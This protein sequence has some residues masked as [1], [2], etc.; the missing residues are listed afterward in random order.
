[1]SVFGCLADYGRTVDATDIDASIFRK[2]MCFTYKEDI[3]IR[4]IEE[5]SNLLYAAKKYKIMQ[6]DKL[7]EK[8]LMSIIDDD[9]IEEINVLADTYKLKTLRRLTKLHHSRPNPSL[10]ASWMRFEPGGSFPD[11]AI[12]A[13]YSNEGIPICI[14]RCI[15]EGNILP[16]QVDPL[17]E[18]IAISHEGHAVQIVKKFEILC[19][20]NLFWTRSMLGNVLSDAVSGGTTELGETV[21]I[22][23]AVHEGTLKIGK[24]SPLSDSLIVPNGQTEARVDDSYE[25]LIEK[26]LNQI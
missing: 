18:S 5:A 3:Q 9:T 21:Y 20:G 22:G 10:P 19:N 16:G 8:Y 17:S 1:M 11:G 13:G 24:I 4:S 12:I 6:L 14:G 25:V 15:Y 23:R 26:P 7:C 2:I